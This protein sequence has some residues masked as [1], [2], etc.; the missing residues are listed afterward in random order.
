MFGEFIERYW[1]I[2]TL[3]VLGAVVSVAGSDTFGYRSV[4][5][6]PPIAEKSPP[7]YPNLD[8]QLSDLVE[9]F[10]A[11]AYSDGGI[12][13]AARNGL[14]TA[15]KDTSG[16]LTPSG[17]L[18]PRDGS[19]AVDVTIY[20]TR[21]IDAV[22]TF[23][24]SNG[25]SV[26]NM[27]N[28]YLEASVPIALLGEASER[29]GVIRVEP[30]IGPH[31][32]VIPYPNPPSMMEDAPWIPEK[33]PQ[34]FANL[35]S[36]LDGIAKDV[37]DGIFSAS[38]L[39]E[40]ALL[41]ELAAGDDGQPA[42]DAAAL[43]GVTIY[44]S[45]DIGAA[46][47][48]LK[49]NGVTIR[50]SGQTYL[51]AYVPVGLLGQASTQP[52]VIRVEPMI[53]PWL[54]QT[55]MDPCIEDL[56]TLSASASS[57]GSWT[58]ECASENRTGRYARYY[59]FTLAADSVVTIDL[60]SSDANAYL[61]LMRGVDKSGAIV[62]SDDD[63]GDGRNSRIVRALQPG[64]YTI[65]ATTSSGTA[66]E[67]SFDLAIDTTALTFC[68][69]EDLG[70]ISGSQ[71]LHRYGPWSGMESRGCNSVNR[72]DGHARH[73]R[74]TLAENS[75][76][77]ISMSSSDVDASPYAYL[78]DG[79]VRYGDVIGE[80]A[81]LRYTLRPGTY[82]V[83]ATTAEPR[84]ADGTR[85][86]IQ[87]SPTPTI[88]SNAPSEHGVPIWNGLG[89]DGSGIK[90][91]IIDGGFGNYDKVGEE[92]P[93]VTKARCYGYGTVRIT[94]DPRDCTGE[95][96]HGVGDIHGTA[97]VEALV[98]IAPDV[99]LYIANPKT[100]GD[101]RDAVDW[102]VSEGVDVINQSLSWR[103]DGPG[104]GTSPRENSPLRSLDRAVDS[105]ITWVN[106]AGNAHKSAWMSRYSDI[107][108]DRNIE[109]KVVE[110]TEGEEDC[111]PVADESMGVAQ[112]GMSH[113]YFQLRW[114]DTWVGADTDL[115]MFVLD[116]ENRILE[117]STDPQVGR[118]GHV[119]FEDVRVNIPSSTSSS[120][121]RVVVKHS[122]GDAPGW[123][124]LM[125]RG[126]TLEHHTNGSI[127]SP[128]ESANL[129]MLTVGAAP[130]SDEETTGTLG[131][132]GPAPD[133]RTKPDII[134]ADGEMSVTYGGN[135]YGT[136]QASPHVAG[137]AALVRQ[138]F[139]HYEP[140]DVARYLKNQAR[141]CSLDVLRCSW[142]KQGE[143]ED[144]LIAPNNVWGYGIA[145]LAP[146]PV[147]SNGL[148]LMSPTPDASDQFGVSSASTSDG[149][150]IVV[151]ALSDGS[152][153]EQSGAAYVFQ[154]QTVNQWGL[155]W[156]EWTF[157]TLTASDGAAFDA[158]GKSV[159][160]SEDGNTVVVGSPDDGA[161]S[162][163]VF[164][165]PDAGW[166]N[167][168][169]TIKLTASDGAAEDGFGSWVSLSGD[170]SAIVV[171][172]PGNDAGATGAGA[173]YVF[174]KP[175]AGWA[176]AAGTVKLTASDG[177]AND[178]FGSSVSAS[179]DGNTIAIGASGDDPGS[180][181]V[182][183][184]STPWTTAAGTFKLTVPSEVDARAQIGGSVSLS[185]DGDTIVAGSPE[186]PGA[187]Y[188]FTKP[189]T[190]WATTTAARLTGPIGA[191]GQFGYSVSIDSDGSTIAVGAYGATDETGAAYVFTRPSGGWASATAGND[192]KLSEGVSGAGYSVAVS[193]DGNVVVRTALL[194]NRA[195][196]FVLSSDAG[197]KWKDATRNELPDPTI[198]PTFSF[199]VGDRIG[200][201]VAV[202]AD[203]STIVVGAENEDSNGTDSG[204]AYVFTRPSGGWWAD[205][206]PTGV[207][208]TAASPGN[209]DKF[210]SSVAVS[211][212]GS[213]VVIGVP[214]DDDRS[215]NSGAADVFTRPTTGWSS[216]A[217]RA[218]LT[219]SDTGFDAFGDSFGTS[220]AVSGDGNTIAVGAIRDVIAGAFN[221]GSISLFTK[222]ATGWASTS[223]SIKLTAFDGAQY[224]ELGASVSVNTDGSVIVAGA[225]DDDVT[226]HTVDGDGVPTSNS[227]RNAGSAYV[228]SKPPAGW[229]ATSTAVRLIAA[230][231]GVN[232]RFGRSLSM[233][234]NGDTIV[235]GS[236]N[237]DGDEVDNSGSAYVFTR[238]SLGW[239]D[240]DTAT[241]T[242]IKLSATYEGVNAQFGTSVSVNVDGSK[243][244]I[245]E[246]GRDRAHGT[247]AGID[248]GTVYVFSK[249]HGGWNATSTTPIELPSERP[250]GIRGLSVSIGSDL[251][252]TGAAVAFQGAGGIYAYRTLAAPERVGTIAEQTMTEGD[253]PIMV[254]VSGNFRDPD[255][256]ALVYTFESSYDGVATAA[257]S[258]PGM[259]TITPV[260]PGATTIS[261]TATNPN[262]LS[263][264]QSFPVKVSGPPAL[265]QD[266]NAI[267]YDTSTIDLTWTAPADY[268]SAITR[269]ELERKA[270]D[271]SYETVTPA[272]MPS[273]GPTITYRDTGLTEGTRYTYRVQ[274]HNDSGAREW[275]NED[276]ASPAG[277]R[278]ALVALYNG[279]NGAGWSDET[280]WGSNLPLGEWYG[281]TTDFD[282]RVTQ[283]SLSN[284]GLSGSLPMELGD[285][286]RLQRLQLNDN[287][288]Q[289]E[290]PQS[291]T[292]LSSLVEFFFDEN[293]GGLCAPRGDA[294]QTWLDGI[295]DSRG[296]TCAPPPTP[297]PTPTPT[298]TPQPT[299]TRAPTQT[300]III[301]PPPPPAPPPSGGGF[302]GFTVIVV[303]ATPISAEDV[304][305]PEIV[306]STDALEF[307]AVQG[308]GSPPAQPVSVWNS[309]QR[310]NMPF[311][312]SSSTSWLSF[313]PTSASSNS[314]QARV[315]VQ[316]S[317]NTSGLM[318]GTHIGRIT[319]TARG[320]VNTPR[321][322]LVTLTVLPPAVR[323]QVPTN[324]AI[325][326][327][328]SDSTVRLVAPAGAAPGDVEIRLAK[329]DTMS[330]GSPPGARE[331]VVL[332]ADVETFV[333]G[334]TTP[335]P[336]TYSRG[337]DLRFA[338]PEGEEAA[339]AAGRVRLYRVNG[340]QWTLLEHRCETDDAGGVWAVATLTRFS[341]YI[342]T[343]DDAP[344]TPTPAPT[345][346]P[347]ATSV[348][349]ATATPMPTAT[350]TP[351]PTATATRT[352]V[353]TATNTPEPTAIPT[354]T[355]VPTATA[356]PWPTVTFTPVPMATSVPTATAT[357]VPA[358]TRTP[359]PTAT[360]TPVP[361]ATNTPMPT[362]THTPVSVP[363]AR[364]EATATATPTA[365]APPEDEDGGPN[366]IAIIAIVLLLVIAAGVAAVIYLM[367]MQ[368]IEF[369]QLPEMLREQS[370][371]V[372]A[373]IDWQ[374]F[375]E[376][377]KEFFMR[378]RMRVRGG[379]D[380][381]SR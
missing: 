48:F 369:S 95:D 257:T 361:T 84:S 40:R 44:A 132:R 101:L 34:R 216:S 188:V 323:I 365:P 206:P 115:D 338:L 158:F 53:E 10:E 337:V 43:V 127:T 108:G 93:P 376:F 13:G 332:A 106:S 244:A 310:V 224:D 178:A 250:Q 168:A 262:N 134:G 268:G 12:V 239:N 160:I 148:S 120:E 54:D 99:S 59:S 79:A 90:V 328:T 381:G 78:I 37:D 247:G 41:Y 182:F 85:L 89:F 33:Y 153:G 316:V 155:T 163:Y 192:E 6:A 299:P 92:A 22:A 267:A 291:L 201:T 137:M 47:D 109:F 334:S 86:E 293:T 150:V 180:V 50:H 83:E 119:P 339:C 234:G 222:P 173:A 80:G 55:M 347:T 196:R 288:L 251:T 344:A 223:N 213:I 65:E 198:F 181:Y 96:V 122:S 197:A 300:P 19:S 253:S 319:I 143:A 111:T 298:Q 157:V 209:G 269:Y 69:Y 341:T 88:T 285:L 322:I 315:R 97:V 74:F 165:K 123:I 354:A 212:D 287:A 264:T 270:G 240:V 164:T 312:V 87:T 327:A 228:F 324:E 1:P 308:G 68:A 254:D 314:P 297:T 349:A 231:G 204:A 326:I 112:T 241:S 174:T 226:Y 348:P 177:A 49:R 16:R 237:G 64:Q 357:L 309:K 371:R 161:G 130:R 70:T 142:E 71:R 219:T 82:T 172:A 166:A 39:A 114:Q 36:D 61:Y 355:S 331:R 207:R 370:T 63:G 175:D 372:L 335:T 91:G 215:Y 232:H 220:V 144:T 103:F 100:L 359:V 25:A 289:G 367:R 76:V 294:F 167:A 290:I 325:D 184:T 356:T 149:S 304:I 5:Q 185:G 375:K 261:V 7:K 252:A 3:C 27:G 374:R 306:L 202:S 26:R 346:P 45:E 284:N 129:G 15:Q 42:D 340:G 358:A 117:L 125:V 333:A 77:T 107:D 313:S 147:I 58:N 116:S 280:N 258:T 46:V 30:I 211:A 194:S 189:A 156:T 140:Q 343:I 73:Y 295:D 236:L 350:N 23:L 345:A 75:S 225:S 352:P 227:V 146:P 28:S 235:V 186:A 8:S 139:P 24:T 277:D 2:F 301:S 360:A 296:P 265:V 20:V 135:F 113:L 203:E 31:L 72:M 302:G 195:H 205:S 229:S 62:A 238:P 272:P 279:T 217:A 210:G 94:D 32:D 18:D 321:L 162:A 126:A 377:F 379:S 35:T 52:D 276:G 292:N 145:Y 256:G 105:G 336:M 170:G 56:G 330:V 11:R 329:L 364:P 351:A 187:A 307:T 200:S 102:M 118:T 353:P 193:A 317:A 151:G 191:P 124:Q 131:S 230:D 128:G 318:A 320:A 9:A 373:R 38:S 183:T 368:G 29:P 366:V 260:G 273:A 275:S 199:Y 271:G 380:E 208:L 282:G 176:T 141:S 218:R 214:S 233:S 57:A 255:G 242:A 278:D 245:G 17:P 81:S 243:I 154:E 342:M 21:D 263:A 281:V 259:V 98:D 171:G 248:S 363:T 152:A 66:I 136:S 311:T 67:G 121:Y 305:H 246:S 104:D 378:V 221:R 249:P 60:T 274:A 4:D 190:G 14:S 362:A 283:L 303:T 286:E 179:Q 133:R 138:R 51:E 169:G 266:L 110:C 159:S